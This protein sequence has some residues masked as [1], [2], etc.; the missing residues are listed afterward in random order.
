MYQDISWQQKEQGN[1]FR[2]NNHNPITRSKTGDIILSP[3][4]PALIDTGSEI[5]SKNGLPVEHIRQ[6]GK[7]WRNSGRSG[8][9]QANDPQANR[10]QPFS[11]LQVGLQLTLNVSTS[12]T[13]VNKKSISLTVWSITQTFQ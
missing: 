13:M 11:P 4:R 1:N 2:V 9:D 8:Y 12:S 5:G 7:F 3:G 6:S 10:T